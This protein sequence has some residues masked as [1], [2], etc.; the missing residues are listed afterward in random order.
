MTSKNLPTAP[1]RALPAFKL[2]LCHK[3]KFKVTGHTFSDR[4]R[5]RLFLH[6]AQK[7]ERTAQQIAAA[8]ISRVK[9]LCGLNGYEVNVGRAAIR[10]GN[11]I[12]LFFTLR[13]GQ[14][15]SGSVTA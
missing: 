11:G 5:F 12:V 8:G 2:L 6:T 9:I 4:F 3:S 10:A 13:R 1:H 7:T 14:I 15:D